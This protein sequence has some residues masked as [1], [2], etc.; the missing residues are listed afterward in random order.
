MKKDIPAQTLKKDVEE[1]IVID[2]QVKDDSNFLSPYSQ[3][4]SPIIS[5]DVALFLENST[6]SVPAKKALAL[7]IH[8]DCIDAQE[9]II[10]KKA[11]KTYYSNELASTSRE[12]KKSYIIAA[13]LAIIGIL[14]LTAA[15]IIGYYLGSVIWAEVIDIAA[16]V[17]LWEAVDIF[18]FRTRS[19]KNDKKRYSAFVNI[20]IEYTS[21]EQ[22]HVA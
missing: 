11:I 10:Y 9:Q 8:S 6:H 1:R 3:K 22:N 19:L 5:E 21:K 20:K 14:V 17:F 15:Q 12:L 13:I 2:I 4:G 7:Q 18:V 16:W